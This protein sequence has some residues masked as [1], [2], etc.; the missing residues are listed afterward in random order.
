M[1]IGDLKDFLDTLPREMEIAVCGDHE[2]EREG[3]WLD[4]GAEVIGYNGQEYLIIS[5][6]LDAVIA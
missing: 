2:I 4:C 5:Y 1:T 6:D 3:S